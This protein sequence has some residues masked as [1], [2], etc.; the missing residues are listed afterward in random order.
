MRRPLRFERPVHRSWDGIRRRSP[1]NDYHSG[2]N[3]ADP[4]IVIGDHYEQRVL[5]RRPQDRMQY[6]G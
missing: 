2:A 1:R 5:G 4:A 6:D 3:H